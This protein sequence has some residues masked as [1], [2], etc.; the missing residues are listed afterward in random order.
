MKKQKG[1]TLIEIVVSLF[2]YALLALLLVEIMSV[3][4]STMMST[5]QLN[6][7]LSFEGKLADNQMVG[8]SAPE[9]TNNVRIRYGTTDTAGNW[10]NL[11]GSIGD[12][13]RGDE[14]I[15]YNAYVTRYDNPKL[16][17]TID[18][19]EGI[20]YRFITFTNETRTPESLQSYA[21][22]VHIMLMPFLPNRDGI[23]V[24]T[25]AGLAN[26]QAL[27]RKANDFIDEITSIEVNG[28]IIDLNEDNSID[29]GAHLYPAT[30]L[31][32]VVNNSPNR[33]LVRLLNDDN[34]LN[35]ATEVTS[36]AILNL[37]DPATVAGRNQVSN[38][39]AETDR[40]YDVTVTFKAGSEDRL[41]VTLPAA[42][43]YVK[44]GDTES[45]YEQTMVVLDLSKFD[46]ADA[47]VRGEAIVAC[48]SKA[49]TDTYTAADYDRT[50]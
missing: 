44:R 21:F 15:Q 43:M 40:G 32:H 29:S 13:S 42:Y 6:Q 11:A 28:Q 45:Y 7:R 10:T 3:V 5:N 39:T 1:M 36:F 9:G 12:L 19:A 2:L 33:N 30:A 48:R 23:D 22:N 47:T 27:Q 46:S 41:T 34:T 24:S 25:P 50:T 8:N 38:D 49:G 31:P 17:G 20:N 26:A 35:A 14:A 37:A 18:Y 16:H 4:N